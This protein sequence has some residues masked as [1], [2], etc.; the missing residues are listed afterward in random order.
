MVH[1]GKAIGGAALA[2]VGECLSLVFDSFAEFDW[3]SRLKIGQ[4]DNE[5]E[6]RLK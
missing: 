1:S 3:E 6:S 4:A 2:L 5:V